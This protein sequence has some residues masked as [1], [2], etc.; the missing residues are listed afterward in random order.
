MDFDN[1]KKKVSGN[2]NVVCGADLWQDLHE[3]HQEFGINK[4]DI[5]NNF[6]HHHYKTKDD[7]MKVLAPVIRTRLERQIADLKKLEGKVDTIQPLPE[8][9]KKVYVINNHVEPKQKANNELDVGSINNPVSLERSAHKCEF[10]EQAV[11]MVQ[12]EIDS[13]LHDTKTKGLAI[14]FKK[15]GKAYYTRAKNVAISNS[16]LRIRIG[17]TKLMTLAEARDIHAQNLH[18][19]YNEGINPNKIVPKKPRARNNKGHYKA[20]KPVQVDKTPKVEEDGVELL[21]F[22][23]L[24]IYTIDD[25]HILGRLLG[26]IDPLLNNCMTKFNNAL[27]KET[28]RQ[29]LDMFRDGITIAE[30]RQK[31][32]KLHTQYRDDPVTVSYQMLVYRLAKAIY[33]FGTKAEKEA[34]NF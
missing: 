15:H 14:R 25:I 10:T 7:F 11:T 24:K 4:S 5:L 27:S 20:E 6:I 31:S 30:L 33:N 3:L 1:K 22:A 13:W 8:Q 17:D 23:N 34:F 12:G 18:T 29:C 28:H 2:V 32:F 19:I 21:D 16:T 9:P 26:N